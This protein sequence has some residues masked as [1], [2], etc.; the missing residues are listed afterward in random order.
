MA[1]KYVVTPFGIAEV[2]AAA[3]REFYQTDVRKVRGGVVELTDDGVVYV[4]EVR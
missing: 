2:I 1:S 4:I 3:L